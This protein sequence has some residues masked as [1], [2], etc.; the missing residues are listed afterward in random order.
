MRCIRLALD[1]LVVIVMPVMLAAV[2]SVAAGVFVAI[3]GAVFVV[4]FR[5]TF[6]KKLDPVLASVIDGAID[7]SRTEEADEAMV[8][9]LRIMGG[10][11]LALT[12]A[13]VIDVAVAV[14]VHKTAAWVVLGCLVAVWFSVTMT[15]ATG[16]W[17]RKVRQLPSQRPGPVVTSTIDGSMDANATEEA[18]A[19]MVGALRVMG[20]VALAL[21]VALAINVA[22]AVAANRTVPW[23]ALGCL[24]AVWF[25]VGVTVITRRWIHRQ[26]A[27]RSDSS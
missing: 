14:S 5:R 25:S 8:R 22:V 6:V 10:L 17:A 11:A 2:T 3:C 26:P 1:A 24:G 20:F 7:A 19:A 12:V 9:A 4:F 13:V 27:T 16:R 18:N 21:T 23:V 15:V